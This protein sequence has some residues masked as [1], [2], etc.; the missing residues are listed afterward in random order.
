MTE[1]RLGGVLAGG[2]SSRF[3]SPK[4]MALFE[5]RALLDHVIAGLASQC[6]SLVILGGPACPP[7]PVLADDGMQGP[8]AAVVNGLAMAAQ[9]GFTSLLLVPCDTPRLPLDLGDQLQAAIGTAAVA[10]AQTNRLHPA[11]SLW[12]TSAFGSVRNAWRSGTR[13]LVG[14]A[15]SAGPVVTVAFAADDMRNI[16]SRRDL[17]HIARLHRR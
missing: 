9:S 4:A 2:Q 12:R 1:T 6:R 16:N 17:D 7:W 15:H 14:L 11:F 10:M 13:A 5:G 8:G 3:G